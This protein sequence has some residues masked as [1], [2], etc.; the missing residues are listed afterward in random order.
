MDRYAAVEGFDARG[1]LTADAEVPAVHDLERRIDEQ[2]RDM[3][4]ADIDAAQRLAIV[5]E[6][7]DYPDD[8]HV[9]RVGCIAAVIARNLGLPEAQVELIRWA[10]PLHDIGKVAIPDGILLKPAPLTLEELDVMKS[11]TVIGARMLA[12][13]RSPILQMAEE[14]A[15]YHHENWDGTGYTPGLRGE[16]IPLSG[17]IVAVADVFDALTHSRPHKKAWTVPEAV[18]WIESM[19]ARKFDPAVLDALFAGIDRIAEEISLLK[20]DLY[21][22]LDDLP[23]LDV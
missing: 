6:Y 18:D 11:H 2:A 4:A 8:T 14:I 17:R 3:R 19:R 22:Q 15:L 13:S 16:D 23:C 20:V 21:S 5:A 1:V 10:A 9:Q 7:R 12:G